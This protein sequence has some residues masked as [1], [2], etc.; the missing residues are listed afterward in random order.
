M[1]KRAK[2]V[3]FKKARGPHIKP[4]KHKP[5]KWSKPRSKRRHIANRLQIFANRPFSKRFIINTQ[6]IAGAPGAKASS[7]D[8]T[9]GSGA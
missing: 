3:K 4:A 7:T 9:T 6:L 8:A 1:R 5:P 2:R